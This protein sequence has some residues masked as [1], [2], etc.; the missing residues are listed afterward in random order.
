MKSEYFAII[1]IV[2]IILVCVKMFVESD[3]YNLSCIVS[4]EDGNK[5]CVRVKE[6]LNQQDTVDL[7]ARITNK[8][9]KLVKY[10]GEKYPE[11][12]NVKRLVKNFNPRQ[13][14]EILPTSEFTAYSEN[15]GEKLA[16]CTTTKKDGGSMIDENTLMFVAIHELSHIASKSIGHNDEFWKNFKFLLIY[17]EKIKI[18]KPIDYKKKPKKYCG[19]KITD[20]PY[21]DL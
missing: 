20:N 6:D 12:E 4:T 8:C 14:K 1:L 13:V 15:K 3:Y 16:F 2:F 9:K 21:Y 11:R 5:Y 18:Y 7:L 17:A 10:L 19:M